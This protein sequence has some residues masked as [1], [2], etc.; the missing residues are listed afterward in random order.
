MKLDSVTAVIRPRSHYE[1]IDLGMAM[2]RDAGW[3][4]WAPWFLVT[5]PVFALCNYLAWR[6]D[7]LWLA[8]FLFWWLK[9]LLDRVPLFALSR[10]LFGETPGF[11]ATLKALPGLFLRALPGALLWERLDLA[12]S[13]DIPVATLEGLTWFKGARR[14]RLLQRTARGPAVLLTLVC[15]LLQLVVVYGV[16]LLALMFV[17]FEYLPE[18]AKTL[19]AAFFTHAT[20]G[21]QLLVNGIW[22]FA[23]CC[24]EPLYVGAGFALYLN[25]RTEL[26]AWD[27]ELAFRRMAER[28]AEVKRGL[29]AALALLALGAFCGLHTAPARAGTPPDAASV[30]AAATVL[31]PLPYSLPPDAE[32]RF[33]A[34]VKTAYQD[35]DVSPHEFSGRWQWRAKPQPAEKPATLPGWLQALFRWFAAGRDF[36]SKLVSYLPWIIGL[37]LLALAVRYRRWLLG[38][39]RWDAAPPARFD[40]R[41]ESVA[42]EDEKLPVDLAGAA[43]ALWE[44]GEGRAALALLYRGSLARVQDL[45]GQELPHGATEADCLR[46][47]ARLPGLAGEAVAR[48]VRAWQQA[49]YAHRLPDAAAFAALLAAWRGQAEVGA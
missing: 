14:L 30:P 42:L 23:Q 5:L 46:A 33:A 15:F 12:R 32:Q 26:E 10:R 1:A 17:P 43:L 8:T 19:Y 4:V 6:L 38:W 22:Y 31:L 34:G 13:L 7:T 45:G 48:V 49:A 3:G 27:I 35:P 25:R 2:V 9:P 16:W 44:R 18:S 11:L 21:F 20:P 36:T 47:A 37:L 28:F 41:P 39:F 24:I 40:A 29:A